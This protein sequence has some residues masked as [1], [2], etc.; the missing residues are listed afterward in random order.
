MVSFGI[1]FPI[2]CSG[3]FMPFER[4]LMLRVFRRFS[5]P[6]FH[7]ITFRLLAFFSIFISTNLLF[8]LCFDLSLRSFSSFSV[9]SSNCRF[10]IDVVVGFGGVTAISSSILYLLLL[11]FIPS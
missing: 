8:L 9:S 7:P 10:T 1:C 5:S 4:F 6:V 3:Q 2:L 11:H